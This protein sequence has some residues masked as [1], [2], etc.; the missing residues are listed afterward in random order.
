MLV[1]GQNVAKAAFEGSFPVNR[2]AARHLE[3][4]LHDIG[5]PADNVWSSSDKSRHLRSR[6]LAAI[7]KGRP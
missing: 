6:R 1:H 3:D 7:D 4:K 2:G 5:A